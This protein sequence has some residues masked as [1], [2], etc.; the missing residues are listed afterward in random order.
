MR[1]GVVLLGRVHSGGDGFVGEELEG[2]ERHSHGQ[3]CRVGDVEC[4]ETLGPV[5]I[6]CAIKH[7]SVHFVGIFDL[8]SLLDHCMGMS[9]H[10][11][12]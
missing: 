1:E 4:A 9:V 3:R 8:H 7:G 5:D 10:D 11:F 6:L 2:C 12:V